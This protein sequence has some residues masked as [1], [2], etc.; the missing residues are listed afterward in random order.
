M[1][2]RPH[3]LGR[4]LTIMPQ[5]G[6]KAHLYATMNDHDI[7]LDYLLRQGLELNDTDSVPV[8]AALRP[9]ASRCQ[10]ARPTQYGNTA[11]H[12]AATKGRERCACLLVHSGADL[13]ATA[14]VR[15]ASGC[16]L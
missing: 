7:V 16:C 6:R 5:L 13:Y 14:Y 9:L 1:L 4:E 3:A 8:A 10:L 2:P 15:S 11:L 12:W